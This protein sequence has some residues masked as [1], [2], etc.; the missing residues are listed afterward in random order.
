MD[1]ICTSQSFWLSFMNF[2]RALVNLWFVLSSRALDC[3]WYAEL[4][5]WSVSH[6]WNSSSL[7]LLTTSR[8]WSD[9]AISA[10]N[11]CLL[12][13]VNFKPSLNLTQASI[14]KKNYQYLVTL[15]Q[16]AKKRKKIV[17]ASSKLLRIFFI[18]VTGYSQENSFNRTSIRWIFSC[19]YS[20]TNMLNYCP[21]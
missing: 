21:W 18:F 20:K 16:F 2:I 4:I 8:P 19:A 6:N 12:E 11:I 5:L 9:I 14:K 10:I 3:G 7:T 15:L 17:W 1:L 13:R